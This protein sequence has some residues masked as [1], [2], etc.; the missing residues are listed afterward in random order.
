[1]TIQPTPYSL[2]RKIINNTSCKLAIKG[3]VTTIN[4]HSIAGIKSTIP[5]LNIETKASAK[6]YYEFKKLPLALHLL[7]F[8]RIDYEEEKN[9]LEY[10]PESD[11]K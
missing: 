6:R 11:N 3:I 1:M 10:H 9:K 5:A 4:D 8:S 7:S 2:S